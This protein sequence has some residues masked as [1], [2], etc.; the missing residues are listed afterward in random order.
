[1]TLEQIAKDQKQEKTRNHQ[2]QRQNNA[3]L[4]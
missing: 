1:L 2:Y 3:S 4:D